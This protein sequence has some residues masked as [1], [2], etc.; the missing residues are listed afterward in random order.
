MPGMPKCGPKTAAKWLAEYE[1]LDN[2]IAHADEIGGKIGESLRAG[3]PQLPLS[4]KLATI[5]TD[6]AL[7][8]DPTDLAQ[9]DADTAELR[10]LYTRYEFKQA[11]KELDG[12]D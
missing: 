1:T 4:R 3:L 7:E 6:V 11:L 8:P 12:G 2:L 5:R 10:E 9:R